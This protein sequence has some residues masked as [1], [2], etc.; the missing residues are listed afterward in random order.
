MKGICKVFT[1]GVKTVTKVVGMSSVSVYDICMTIAI[2]FDFH[3]NDNPY[4]WRHLLF[5]EEACDK[6]NFF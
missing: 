1:E 2:K 6:Y 3:I 5:A 4:R